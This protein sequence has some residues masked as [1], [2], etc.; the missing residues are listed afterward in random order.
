DA[1]I[2]PHRGIDNGLPARRRGDAV[3]TGHRLA[4]PGLDFG[5]HLV[6]GRRIATAPVDGAARVIDYDPGAEGGQLQRIGTAQATAGTG[7]DRD[8]II[9]TNAHIPPSELVD[10]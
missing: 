10:Q 1:A 2:G 4:A 9:E 8:A 6:R 5:D 7:N 3:V